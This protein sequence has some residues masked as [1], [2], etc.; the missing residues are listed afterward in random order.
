MEKYREHPLCLERRSVLPV[1][2]NQKMNEYLKEIAE[3]CGLHVIL[4]TH[5]AR[6][7]FASTATLGNDVPIRVVKE[8]LGHSSVKQTEE[9][10]IIEQAAIGREM[11]GLKKNT[12]R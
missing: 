10:A 8:M 3:I 12:G 2:S 1:I 9:Y 5:K 6:R 7:T 4:N 11:Q